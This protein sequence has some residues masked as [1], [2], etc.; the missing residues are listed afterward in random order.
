MIFKETSVRGAYLVDADVFE[1]ERGSFARLFSLE[2]FEEH[3]LSLEVT[4]SAV[5]F[6]QKRGTLRGL[7]YQAPPHAQAKLVRAL[8]GAALD[9]IVDLRVGS[10]SYGKWVGV[11]L[12]P[13]GKQVF[14]PPGCAHGYA[15]LE[16]DT[17][18]AY[19]CDAYYAAE[20]EG[21]IN[22]ADPAIGIDW[23][24][25]QRDAIVS[26]KDRALPMLRDFV[27]PFVMEPA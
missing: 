26:E 6:N 11:T 13:N 21:G 14:I 24:V 25:S 1:D 3:G 2:E 18:I 5:S 10:P 17:E 12:E 7:H 16:P 20:A 9:V 23:P 27:S 4:A 22:F 19:K 15:T 8:R